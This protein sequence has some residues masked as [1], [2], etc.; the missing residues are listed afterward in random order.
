MGTKFDHKQRVINHRKGY[1]TDPKI[2][3]A[4]K[5]FRSN[6]EIIIETETYFGTKEKIS[7]D[8]IS[9]MLT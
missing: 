8:I 3:L 4:G 9:L 1:S 5:K 6:K 7:S 2:I